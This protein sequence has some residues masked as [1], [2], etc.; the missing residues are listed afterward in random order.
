MSPIQSLIFDFDGIILETEQPIF[1]SWQELYEMFDCQLRFDD[2]AKIIGT[3][4]LLFDPLAE[5][6]RQSGAQIDQEKLLLR[7]QRE[8]ELTLAQPV[9]PGVQDYLED[10]RRLGVKLGVASS[11]PAS[12]VVG[13]LERLGLR[14]YFDCV[15]TC[16]DV[17]RAKPDPELY[18]SA[19]DC[20][21]VNASQAIAIEDSPNGAHAAQRAGL[22]CIV[23]P[24]PITSRLNLD[25]ADLRLD[26]LADLPLQSLLEIIPSKFPMP[27]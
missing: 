4:E 14:H 5:L 18:L 22:F 17:Q 7:K 11:S 25:H 27:D 26:S 3:Q 13:H 16:D 2:W 21:G 1:Q 15:R 19:M 24:T 10:A 8:T 20:L 9:L 12:W 23:V 6:E